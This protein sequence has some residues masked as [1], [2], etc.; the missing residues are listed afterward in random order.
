MTIKQIWSYRKLPICLF[1][2]VLRKLSFN[3]F[4]WRSYI[5]SPL[6]LDGASNISIGNY[7]YIAYKTWLAA[8]PLTGQNVKLIIE[9]GCSI[10]CLSLYNVDSF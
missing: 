2:A 8:K 3:S 10:G 6:R 5:D 9:D 7:C 1:L 4:G